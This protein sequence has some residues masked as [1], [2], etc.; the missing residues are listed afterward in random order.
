[1]ITLYPRH[2]LDI[3]TPDLL[4]CASGKFNGRDATREA[5]HLEDEIGPHAIVTLSVR[6]AWDLMLTAFNLPPGSEVIMSAV[7]IPD[8]A[9][10]AEAHGLVVIPID[11]DPSTMTPRVDLYS[12]AFNDRTRIVLLAHLLGGSF[13]IS[14]YA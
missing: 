9:R 2:Y 5:R 14:R 10:I 1:M 7:S 13:D 12:R 3:S 6:S 11:L 8:M 4:R